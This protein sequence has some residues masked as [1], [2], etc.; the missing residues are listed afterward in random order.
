MIINSEEEGVNIWN[1][2]LVLNKNI[3]FIGG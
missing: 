2:G 1:L 3:K